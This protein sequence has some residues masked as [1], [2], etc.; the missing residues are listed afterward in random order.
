MKKRIK[1]MY[2]AGD[3]SILTALLSSNSIVDVINKVSYFNEIYD[4][5][6]NLLNEYQA[7]KA[8]VESRVEK[9]KK[10]SLS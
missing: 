9:W 2:E 7:T 10:T 5:D 3:N 4:Y 6:R 1:F 8:E